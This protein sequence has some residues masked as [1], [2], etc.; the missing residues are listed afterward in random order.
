MT[1]KS[2]LPIW[3]ADRKGAL[4]NTGR[5]NLPQGIIRR[6]RRSGWCSTADH[7]ATGV[8]FAPNVVVPTAAVDIIP[9]PSPEGLCSASRA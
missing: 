3:K 8:T 6:H 9:E 5:C 1:A 2:E 4:I 7:Q